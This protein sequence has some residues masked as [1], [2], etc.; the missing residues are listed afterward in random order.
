MISK[1]V[2]PAA[3]RAHQ[4]LPA[5]N[6]LPRELLPLLGKPALQLLLEEGVIAGMK[7][8]TVVTGQQTP[9]I[10]NFMHPISA[11]DY[12]ISDSN[13]RKQLNHFNHL[14]D[15]IDVSSVHQ[16]EPL[17]TGHALWKARHI[18]GKEI[19]AV[20]MPDDILVEANPCLK[21]LVKHAQLEKCSILAVQEVPTEH[22]SNYGVIG[23]KKQYSPN[24]FHI[25]ELI[26]KPAIE[27]APSNLAIVGRYIL[28]PTIFDI[29]DEQVRDASSDTE[30][31][32]T[33]AI[34]QLIYSGEK[35]FAY[36]IQGTRF[37]IS[38]P[39]E[40]LK[41]NIA[42]AL[43]HPVYADAMHDYLATLDTEMLVMQGKVDMLKQKEG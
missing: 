6:A 5:C 21:Q 26:E 14:L 37:D 32:L 11:T 4:F 10:E 13:L 7:S 9:F 38:S 34:Q 41:A 25:R 2:I 20:M 28:S 1:V 23:V 8:F 16:S 19:V 43:K 24:L 35:V 15:I 18:I 39:L 17:G 33:N 3:L 12:S 30:V 31:S 36:K 27:Q 29:L 22:L 40:W 42:L